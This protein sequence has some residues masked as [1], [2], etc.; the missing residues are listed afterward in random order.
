MGKESR[1]RRKA[2]VPG[3]YSGQILGS[4]VDA[5][6]VGDGVLADKTAKRMFAGRSVSE[7]SRKERLEALGQELVGL[8]VVPD[9]DWQALGAGF[10]EDLKSSDVLAD[11]I[12]LMCEWWDMLMERVQ[13]RECSVGG[14]GSGRP[15]VSATGHGGR[16]A[17][18]AGLGVS[19]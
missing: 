14:C 2:M 12:G 9:V 13:E 17:P 15:A 16:V 3:Q 10:R 8:G 19:G 5:L 7:R 6:D 1:R 4:V 18:H 11:V